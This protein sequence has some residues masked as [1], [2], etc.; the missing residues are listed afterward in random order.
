MAGTI[1]IP[2]FV[3]KLQ[4][5]IALEFV[6]SELDVER[7]PGTNRY[8][9]AVVWDGFGRSNVYKRQDRVWKIAEKSLAPGELLRISMILT[10]RPDEL[11]E[12]GQSNGR[13]K[14]KPPKGKH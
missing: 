11:A 14:K 9:L 13:Q 10:L 7:V 12:A 1:K 5:K 6:G 8:R 2:D 3:K 4:D